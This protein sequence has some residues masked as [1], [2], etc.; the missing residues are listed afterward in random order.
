[1][2]VRPNKHKAAMCCV[3]VLGAVTSMPMRKE[4]GAG[5]GVADLPHHVYYASMQAQGNEKTASLGTK[6]FHSRGEV[7]GRFLPPPPSSS[8]PSPT[9]AGP[10]EV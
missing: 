6:V 8:L 10:N 5:G 1:M 4:G 7:D 2:G 9:Q 3:A